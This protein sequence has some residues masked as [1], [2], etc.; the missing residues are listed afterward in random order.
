ME[1]DQD[2]LQNSLHPGQP[3]CTQPCRKAPEAPPSR[4]GAT[5]RPPEPRSVRGPVSPRLRGQDSQPACPGEQNHLHL[6]CLSYEMRVT[7]RPR[8]DRD[9]APALGEPVSADSNLNLRGAWLSLPWPASQGGARQEGRVPR[10]LRPPPHPGAPPRLQAT[11][12]SAHRPRGHSVS[13]LSTLGSS[14]SLV[15]P[16]KESGKTTLKSSNEVRG[17]ERE[18]GPSNLRPSFFLI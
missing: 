4:L 2:P 12:A 6:P 10:S 8:G 17:F 3:D 7:L 11:P 5:C 9:Q 13:T 18:E 16:R 14:C 1:Q 15:R